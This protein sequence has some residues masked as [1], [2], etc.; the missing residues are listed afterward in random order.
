M[1]TSVGG[2]A[3]TGA[4]VGIAGA[5]GGGVMT[6]SG[7]IEI[8]GSFAAGGIGIGGRMSFGGGS[9]DADGMPR[10]CGGG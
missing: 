2:A 4:K 6:A 9:V 1:R 5:G 3:A 7:P 8:K 10:V